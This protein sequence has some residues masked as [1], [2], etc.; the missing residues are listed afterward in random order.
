MIQNLGAD[1]WGHVRKRREDFG[2]RARKMETRPARG[3]SRKQEEASTEKEKG[4]T[5]REHETGIR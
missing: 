5:L 4:S 1:H 2:S 3:E